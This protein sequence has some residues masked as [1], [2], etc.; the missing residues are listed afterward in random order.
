MVSTDKQQLVARWIFRGIYRVY[1]HPLRKFPG[2]KLSSFTRLPKITAT[3]TGRLHH[4][5]NA[6]HSQYGEI[7][8]VSPDELSFI[9]PDA[10][11]D[12][13]GHGS[14]QG[15]GTQG[16]VPPKHWTWYGKASNGVEHLVQAQEPNHSRV[17]RVFKPAFSDRALKEQEPL[18]MKYVEQLVGNLRRAVSEEP[19]HKFD[20]VKNYNCKLS[21]HVQTTC[22][23]TVTDFMR[24]VTTFDVMGDLTFGES[25]HMLD[26][27]RYDPWVSVI[28]ASIK[29]AS[30]FNL[31]HHY[32]WLSRFVGANLPAKLQKKKYEHF[33]YSVERVSKRL[34]RGRTTEGKDLWDL[35]LSQDEGKQLSRGEMDSNATLFMLAGT[36]TTA[37]LLSGLTYLLLKNPGKMQA[38]SEEIRGAFEDEKEMSMEAIAALPYLA[39]CLKEALRLYPPVPLALPHLTPANGSTI[40]G[41]FVPP[42]VRFA[43]RYQDLH[44]RTLTPHR[45][46]LPHRITP[47]TPPR[48]TSRSRKLSSPSAGWATSGSKTTARLHCSRS[49]LARETVSVKSKYMRAHTHIHSSVQ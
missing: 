23:N 32:P 24:P 38:L 20:M 40:C 18:F 27:S 11:R 44:V 2:P 25:L 3:W 14:G 17:R 30:R 42:G 22:R 19:E 13:Y 16:S 45:Q 48:S 7:V 39:A 1:F 43:L 15:K 12:I 31:I 33:Q 6:L 21:I 35:A 49:Q 47:C 4:Y 10:W 8:R 29:F 26:D 28:F 41:Q 5:N 37:T 34:E 46:L 36:E 9:H